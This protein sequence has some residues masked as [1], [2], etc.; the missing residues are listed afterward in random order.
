MF[1]TTIDNLTNLANLYSTQGIHIHV[2]CIRLKKIKLRVKQLFN[3]TV[4]KPFIFSTSHHT[5]SFSHLFQLTQWQVQPS[6]T[7]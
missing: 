4:I 1:V 3:P 7:M 2:H 6:S 5:Q